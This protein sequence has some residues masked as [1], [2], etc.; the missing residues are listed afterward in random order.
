MGVGI[1]VK[2]TE[3]KKSPNALAISIMAAIPEPL[4]SNPGELATVSQ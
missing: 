4:S 1:F 3:E 2:K